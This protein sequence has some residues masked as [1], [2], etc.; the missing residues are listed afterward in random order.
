MVFDV[1]EDGGLVTS[2][3]HCVHQVESFL[4]QVVST[5]H[6]DLQAV[7]LGEFFRNI[8]EVLRTALDISSTVSPLPSL[9]FGLSEG[10]ELLGMRGGLDER[11]GGRSVGLGLPPED[12]G[13][14]EE[15]SHITKVVTVMGTFFGNPDDDIPGDSS[16][17]GFVLSEEDGLVF[18]INM[19]GLVRLEEGFTE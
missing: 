3:A 13:R 4:H 17:G 1:D 2:P 11:D 7:L 16:G 8:S 12:I 19:G 10:D 9:V 15:I 5:D 18:A 6:C 14:G